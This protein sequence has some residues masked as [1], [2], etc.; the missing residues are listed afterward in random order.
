MIA[1]GEYNFTIYEGARF[2]RLFQIRNSDGANLDTTGYTVRMQARRSISTTAT[3][4]SLAS[5]DNQIS[6]NSSGLITLAIPAS[7]T[8]TLPGSEVLAYDIEIVSGVIVDRVLMGSI[9]ISAE[10]TR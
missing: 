1:P 5:G 7:V 10:V 4:L 8:A 6:I 3:V 9:T 2:E